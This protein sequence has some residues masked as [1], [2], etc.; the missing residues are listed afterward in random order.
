LR[1]NQGKHIKKIERKRKEAE[2]RI[3][4]DSGNHEKVS[5]TPIL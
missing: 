2:P 1:N 5:E 3:L 4:D